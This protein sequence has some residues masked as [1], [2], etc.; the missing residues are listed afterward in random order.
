MSNFFEKLHIKRLMYFLV[1]AGI[2]GVAATW[3]VGY[4]VV[5]AA[6]AKVFLVRTGLTALA[7][8]VILVALGTYL[9]NHVARRSEKMV[10]ALQALAK[11]DLTY[12]LKISG[13]D[14][15]AW[16]CWEYSCA[17]TSFTAIVNELKSNAAHLASAA[18]ELSTITA[19]HSQRGVAKQNA[20][21][22][23]V[24]A[25]MTQMSQTVHDVANNAARAA[26]AAQ[27]ADDEARKG[28]DVVK[29]TVNTIGN[30]AQEVKR[31][32]SAISKLKEDSVS[33]GT[34]LDVIRGIAEQTNLLALNA[35]IEAA[36]AGEQGRGFAVVADEVR[37]L[38]SR[39]QESTQEIQAMIERLQAGAIEAV[40]AMEEGQAKAESSVEQ[41]AHAGESLESINQVVEQIKTMNT[42]IA[43]AAEQQSATAV[44]INKNVVNI[45]SI[46]TET[47]QGAQQTAQASDEL[48]R[49][50]SQLQEMVGKFVVEA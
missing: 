25:A 26:T 20:E 24:A 47:S 44:E 45:S 29:Q 18:E 34:V 8:G 30:L 36:R 38:A 7:S 6:S 31:T 32:S 35:A 1:G 14:E 17:Q 33:I 43:A 3:T 42:Q 40:R 49:L 13:K 27:E 50:A 15:F 12:K 46:S 19:A 28:F 22:E 48:A 4:L 9:G 41:A 23:Q 39:T 37:S 21:T 16:M 2:I 5:P 11:G 10:G